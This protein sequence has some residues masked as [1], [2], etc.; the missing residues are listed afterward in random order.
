MALPKL[1]VPK[2]TLTIPST[3]VEVEFRPYLVGEEKILLIAAES[4]NETVMMKA[5]AD[6]IERCLTNDIN[7]KKLKLYDIEYI[8]THLKSKS[9]GESSEVIIKCDKCDNP[10]TI[11]LNV[12]N[13]VRVTNLTS[14]KSE[15]KIQISEDVGMVLKHLSMSDILVDDSK[16]SQVNQVFNKII[17]CIDYIYEGDTIYDVREEG[18]AEMYTFIE[19]LNTS[20]FK[21]ISDFMENMPKVELNT[22]FKCTQ[23]AKTNKVK[24]SGIDN[25]F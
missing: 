3:Q 14:K 21:L 8:F 5:V 16:I 18:T 12:D 6:I 22:T 23:C 4:E 11:S 10:N 13:D 1:A 2:Y 20:Q 17:Q 19:S 25:F 9:A 15:F 24:L 7:T